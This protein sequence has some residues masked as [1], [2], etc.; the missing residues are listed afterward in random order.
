MID[1]ILQI[2]DRG[3]HWIF[4]FYEA[5]KSRKQQENEKEEKDD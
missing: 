2:L 3:V 5:F 4:K 1:Y